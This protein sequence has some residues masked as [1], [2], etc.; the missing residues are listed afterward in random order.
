VVVVLDRE[1]EGRFNDVMCGGLGVVLEM[2][3][4]YIILF[5]Y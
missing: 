4:L 5:D 1:M 2:D 3:N